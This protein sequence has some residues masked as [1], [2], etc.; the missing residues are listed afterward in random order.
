L[1]DR[2]ERSGVLMY[3]TS[4]LTIEMIGCTFQI[5]KGFGVNTYFY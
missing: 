1:Y 2:Y 3:F 4:K 5:L